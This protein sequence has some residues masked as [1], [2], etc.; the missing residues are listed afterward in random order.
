[1]TCA[2]A[3]LSLGGG[4]GVGVGAAPAEVH[5]M[6]FNNV[7]VRSLGGATLCVR[8]LEMFGSINKFGEA[9]RSKCD[10][11]DPTSS[12]FGAYISTRFEES[13]PATSNPGTAAVTCGPA[14]TRLPELIDEAT[15]SAEV[16]SVQSFPVLSSRR[17]RSQTLGPPEKKSP[18]SE[19]VKVRK[20]RP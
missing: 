17:Y 7:N 8:L 20:P 19:S 2:F 9:L 18:V 14:H 12:G 15:R 13:A 5:P 16:M 4:V 3:K 10:T 1:M 11:E 6:S